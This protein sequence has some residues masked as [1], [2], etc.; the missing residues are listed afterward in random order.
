MKVKMETYL[1]TTAINGAESLRVELVPV[2]VLPVYDT[3][4]SAT[5]SAL[6]IEVDVGFRVGSPTI[7]TLISRHLCLEVIQTIGLNLHPAS[8]KQ[9]SYAVHDAKQSALDTK[10]TDS[11]QRSKFNGK[12]L[13]VH[14]LRECV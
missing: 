5:S 9:E 8:G 13:N 10:C 1:G 4:T 2:L 3:M 12:N 14:L 6:N 7:D 11:N